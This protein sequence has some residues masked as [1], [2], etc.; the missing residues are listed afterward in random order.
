MATTTEHVVMQ[1]D[2]EGLDPSQIEELSSALGITADRFT[3]LM[4]EEKK[5]LKAL[6]EFEKSTG[7]KGMNLSF[8]QIQKTV[9]TLSNREMKKLQAEANKTADST[10]AI[11]DETVRMAQEMD[12]AH[13]YALR[14]NAAFD[15]RMAQEMNKMH[16]YALKLNRD[17]DEMKIKAGKE[18]AAAIEKDL[19][20]A[21]QKV[22]GMATKIGTVLGLTGGGT[23]AYSL[24]A[25]S[26]F[27]VGIAKVQ[28]LTTDSFEKIS[29]I[30]REMA[31]DTGKSVNELTEGLYQTLS[32]IGDVEG[33]YDVLN[34]ANQL[35]IGGFTNTAN[36]VDVLSTVMNAYK[37][38]AEEVGNISDIL[39]MTQN[40]GKTT[41]DQLASSLGNVIPTAAMANVS[42]EQLSTGMALVTSNGIN[43][44]EAATSL[45][46]MIT[47]LNTSGTD[48][49]KMFRKV[50]GQSFRSYMA[51]TD[52]LGS[53][54]R[55]LGE[56]A[57]KTGLTLGDIFNVRG[58]KGAATIFGN[59]EKWSYF[60]ESIYDAT[61]TTKAAVESML[62][63][64]QAAMAKIKVIM[65]EVAVNIGNALAPT[66]IK[67][68]ESLRQI[69]FEKIFS[70]E[71]IATV[72]RMAK[73]L[74]LLLVTTKSLGIAWNVFNT[75][76][77]VGAW[78]TR[79]TQLNTETLAASKSLTLLN[80][81]LTKMTALAGSGA[82]LAGW[83][84]VLGLGVAVIGKA[85][86]SFMN[87]REEVNRVN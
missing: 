62:N 58:T 8:D 36:A 16:D 40:K 61:G 25:F 75:V 65:T 17:F 6:E 45:N 77:G 79:I 48:A 69:D 80:R 29:E 1:F 44:A 54:L 18:L 31:R 9:S 76:K 27:E 49:D 68:S 70:K 46:T 73:A 10:K 51:T 50:F 35:A 38:S 53:A 5:A 47:E 87:Y 32:A 15:G 84:V 81:G 21:F 23:G 52:D 33:K 60:E 20:G 41:V 14:M 43:T 12:K 39:I 67:F 4:V 57:R 55:G 71:N 13:E 74:G 86:N 56:E 82:A 30:T 11:S 78:Y 34:T 83:G 2:I 3:E 22:Q 28:T 59:L 85:V 26:D 63:T 7:L 24:N 72:S 64:L 19:A 42:F 37:K 66:V